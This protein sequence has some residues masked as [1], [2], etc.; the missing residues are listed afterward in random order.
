MSPES[1]SESQP[2]SSS[3]TDG[4]S[5]L[6]PPHP[7]EAASPPQSGPALGQG[8]PRA[9][10]LICGDPAQAP[11]RP[12]LPALAGDVPF[13]FRLEQ[14]K[15]KSRSTQCRL[16]SVAKEQKSRNQVHRAILAQPGKGGLILRSREEKRC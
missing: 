5:I 12:R 13:P 2:V 11:A 7:P 15:P 9:T 16:Y 10:E 1:G 6:A 8:P 14:P 3:S 4:L